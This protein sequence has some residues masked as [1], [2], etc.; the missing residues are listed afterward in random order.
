MDNTHVRCNRVGYIISLKISL[1]A[2]SVIFCSISIS[3]NKSMLIYMY[4]FSLRYSQW[5][6]MIKKKT[7]HTLSDNTVFLTKIP[8]NILT[9]S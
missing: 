3:R 4:K 8:Y 1:L 6:Q 5:S 7:E 9:E 2:Y